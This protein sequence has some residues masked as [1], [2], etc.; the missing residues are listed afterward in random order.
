MHPCISA[1]LSAEPVLEITAT[2]GCPVR[3]EYCP[4]DLLASEAKGL[5]KSLSYSDFVSIVDNIDLD[6]SVNWTG[7]SEPTFPFPGRY[8]NLSSL[9]RIPAKYIY[10]FDRKSTLA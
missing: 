10:N 9:P 7:Y 2:L 5:K 8:D 1:S 3:W 6:I 4:Q